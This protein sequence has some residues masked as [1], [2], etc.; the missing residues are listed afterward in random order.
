MLDVQAR[1]EIDILYGSPLS[2]LSDCLR[3]FLVAAPGHKL[4]GC[5]FNA[6]ES[7]VLNWLAGEERVLELYRT[8][9]K[10]YEYNASSIFKVPMD[11]V[12][13][14]QRQIGK[15]AELA[16]GYQGGVG[17]FQS[18]ARNYGVKVPDKMVDEIK[19]AWRDAHPNVVSYWHALEKAAICAVGHPSKEFTVGPRGRNIRYKTAGSFLWCRLPSGR[20]LCYPYPRIEKFDTPWGVPKDGLTY[21]AEDSLTRKWERQKA[22]G[23]LLAENITQAVSRD[24]LAEAMLRVEAQKYA[25]VMHVHDEIV[26]EVPDDFGSVKEM[27]QIMTVLPAWAT[28]LP[29]AAEGWSGKR[30]QK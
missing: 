5:D 4:I 19:V 26:C 8:I 12:T 13:K 10:V 14:E 24:L 7:R 30:Y 29:I 11:Q 15:V 28:D 6:I 3:G 21:M 18:M 1:D 16:L 27:E 25:V 23:G 17:A 9:G 20:V 22:Y 2:V